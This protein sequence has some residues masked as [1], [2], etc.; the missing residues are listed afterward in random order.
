MTELVAAA[1]ARWRVEQDCREL[2]EELGLDHFEGRSWPGWGHH[3]ALVSAAFAFLRE[4]Q[5][6]RHR[7]T[8]KKAAANPA[9]DAPAPAGHPRAL[10]RPVSLVPDV[11]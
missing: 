8:Q 1:K 2:K 7:G 4:E 10:E 11:L 6:R 3:V 5:R 9:D